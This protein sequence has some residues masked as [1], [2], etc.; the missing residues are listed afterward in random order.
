MLVMIMPMP[1]AGAGLFGM[2]LGIG[3]PIA[4]LVRYIVFGAVLGAD[5]GAMAERAG[6]GPAAT[7]TSP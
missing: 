6:G 7:P 1:L 5:H 3:T 2:D 4:T